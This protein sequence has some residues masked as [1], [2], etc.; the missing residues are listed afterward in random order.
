[1]QKLR[2]TAD[3]PDCMLCLGA[4]TSTYLRAA[5]VGDASYVDVMVPTAR[6]RHHVRELTEHCGD[7]LKN[8]VSAGMRCLDRTFCCTHAKVEMLRVTVSRELLEALIIINNIQASINDGK[9]AGNVW[10]RCEEMFAAYQNAVQTMIDRSRGHPMLDGFRALKVH[11]VHLHMWVAHVAVVDP[12]HFVYV[13]GEGTG[14]VPRGLGTLDHKG[15]FARGWSAL[16]TWYHGGNGMGQY[17]PRPAPGDLHRMLLD[18]D[19]EWMDVDWRGAL[20]TRKTKEI[21]AARSVANLDVMIS[22][23]AMGFPVYEMEARRRREPFELRPDPW[24]VDLLHNDWET[25]P[26]EILPAVP[27]RR[28]VRIAMV[29][30][31]SRLIRPRLSTKTWW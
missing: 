6:C 23:M 22:G 20:V 11:S 9:A 3:Q 28:G 19:A 4:D 31:A 24:P 10:H 12:Y 18:D 29:L 17:G 27:D 26:E 14:V 15:W 30:R 5:Y 16:Q 1:M 8:Q 13:E 21:L 2:L 7:W 25:T